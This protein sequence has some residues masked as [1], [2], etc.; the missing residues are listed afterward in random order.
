MASALSDDYPKWYT[1]LCCH[2]ASSMMHTSP[3]DLRVAT[4][5]PKVSGGRLFKQSP[6]YL[7]KSGS[8]AINSSNIFWVTATMLSV[9]GTTIR[10]VC[11]F[12]SC[13]KKAFIKGLRLISSVGLIDGINIRPNCLASRFIL[14]YRCLI[15]LTSTGLLGHIAN[16]TIDHPNPEQLNEILWN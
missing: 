1:I 4:T 13:T 12:L 10:S 5:I 14:I 9:S 7:A 2:K 16:T 8:T 3:S 15:C 11:L 6:L